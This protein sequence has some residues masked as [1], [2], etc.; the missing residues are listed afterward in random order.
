MADDMAALVARV[1]Y[2]K[3]DVVGYSLG[4]GVALRMAIQ[5]PDS[6]RRVALVST[7]FSASGF[8]PEMRVQQ[9]QV[10]AKLAPKMKDT[11]M[12]QGYAAVAPDASEFPRLLDTLGDYMRKDYD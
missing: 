10:S 1:G 9:A 7:P 11:P 6:V 12:Y 5:K 2:P 3:V 8:Y 4:G